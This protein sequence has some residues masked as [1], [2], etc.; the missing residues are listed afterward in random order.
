MLWSQLA[1]LRINGFLKKR[2]KLLA[3][4]LLAPLYRLDANANLRTV[5][6]SSYYL[7]VSNARALL[8]EAAV[9]TNYLFGF[10]TR[11][12]G[13]GRPWGTLNGEVHVG[14]GTPSGNLASPTLAKRVPRQW[15]AVGPVPG[16]VGYRN[17]DETPAGQLARHQG[18]YANTRTV[19]SV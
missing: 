10:Q 11:R 12:R 19:Q 18:V 4:S 3:R 8:S 17:I 5:D 15:R 14:E 1:S 6:R 9:G 16:T 13:T 2:E 7:Q